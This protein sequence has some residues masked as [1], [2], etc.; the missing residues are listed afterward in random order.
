MTSNPF[1]LPTP[2]N[3]LSSDSDVRG[4]SPFN[5]STT[6]RKKKLIRRICL[7]IFN[8]EI[9]HIKNTCTW[10]FLSILAVNSLV[11]IYLCI[12]CGPRS[13]LKRFLMPLG[14]CKKLMMYDQV[15]GPNFVRKHTN[16]HLLGLKW[17]KPV[18]NYSYFFAAH[19]TNYL[20][21]LAH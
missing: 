18:K 6:L 15:F 13:V 8:Q 10:I 1:Y 20:L 9:D 16:I 3:S 4:I 12:L 21:N 11:Q 7:Q 5:C 19:R 2:G 14:P 17:E